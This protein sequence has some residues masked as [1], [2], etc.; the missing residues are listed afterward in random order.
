MKT[1]QPLKYDVSL[2]GALASV[3]LWPFADQLAIVVALSCLASFVLGLILIK[4]TDDAATFALGI[5]LAPVLFVQ[6]LHESYET[7]LFFAL[8]V[9][10]SSLVAAALGR[11]LRREIARRAA[12]NN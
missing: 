11:A 8:P 5:T 6:E 7:A 2:L 4:K 12:A 9:F 10:G 1:A 3:L